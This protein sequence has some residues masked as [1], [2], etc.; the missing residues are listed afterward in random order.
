MLVEIMKDKINIALLVVGSMFLYISIAFAQTPVPYK[1]G[2][3]LFEYGFAGAGYILLGYF[4]YRL[5][6]IV[7]E[8]MND[9]NEI[10]RK[11]TQAME[12]LKSAIEGKLIGKK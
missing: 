12:E 9:S 11:N 2:N 7:K 3:S 1:S 8:Q 6:N 5:L 4:C 10:T